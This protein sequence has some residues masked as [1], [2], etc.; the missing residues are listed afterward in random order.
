MNYGELRDNIQSFLNRTD[1]SN[2]DIDTFVNL[3]LGKVSRTVRTAFQRTIYNYTIPADWDGRIAIPNDFLA[4]YEVRVRSQGLRRITSG[5]NNIFNGFYV[6][7]AYVEVYYN[8]EADGLT[9]G[10][11]VEVEYYNTFPEATDLTDDANPL[12]ASI[13]PD[14]TIFAALYF[15]SLKYR[16]N[17]HGEWLN[18]Y[19]T[20]YQEVEM[21]SNLEWEGTGGVITPYGGGIA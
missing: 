10:E 18:A 5:Q 17:R 12:F 13:I 6:E 4:M 15:A 1:V 7:G 2:N 11:V 8:L 16:D 9:E 14:L 20:A 19:N 3:G 21:Q